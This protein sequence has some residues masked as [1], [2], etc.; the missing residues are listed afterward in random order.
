MADDNEDYIK[1][2]ERTKA[3][4]SSFYFGAADGAGASAGSSQSGQPG[5]Q[6]PTARAGPSFSGPG[7]PS[8]SVSLSSIDAANF[9]ADQHTQAVLRSL[10]LA[11]LMQEHGSMVGKIKHLDG[12]MQQLVYENYNKFITATDTIRSMKQSL[13][14]MDGE[15][16]RLKSTA[17]KGVGG[18]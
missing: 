3:L 16:E 12:D 18:P 7:N 2:T 14:S 8:G 9:N 1:R 10:P 17:G 4:L 11:K 13:D 5:A 6:L 15:L